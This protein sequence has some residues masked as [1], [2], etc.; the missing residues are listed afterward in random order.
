MPFDLLETTALGRIDN[1][2]FPDKRL[3]IYTLNNLIVIESFM[4]FIEGTIMDGSPAE[5]K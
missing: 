3:A 5:R 1:Q 4:K 2:H